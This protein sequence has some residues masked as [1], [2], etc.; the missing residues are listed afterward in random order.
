MASCIKEY[1]L[2][3]F[4]TTFG[5]IFGTKKKITKKH[6]QAGGVGNQHLPLTLSVFLQQN[7]QI[8]GTKPF[9]R[10]RFLQHYYRNA[11]YRATKSPYNS[12]RS[13]MVIPKLTGNF[14]PDLAK[15]RFS[16]NFLHICLRICSKI[17]T[18]AAVF[19]EKSKCYKD[20]GQ[21]IQA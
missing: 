16:Q 18:F 12:H 10:R 19:T 2:S 13:P 21:A 9:P 8:F 14:I 7:L 6:T 15:Y 17:R 3:T 20:F 5:T 1:L 11:L 4:S